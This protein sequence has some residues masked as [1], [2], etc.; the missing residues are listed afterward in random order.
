MNL[1]FLKAITVI[2]GVMIVVGVTVLGVLL[3]TRASDPASG[4][5]VVD[6][7]S[8]SLPEGTRFVAADGDTESLVLTLEK[9]STG[10]SMIAI[11]DVKSG[12]RIHL[13][14]LTPSE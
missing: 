8:L 4:K 10:T 12:K 13:F 14:E 6:A 5:E 2:M 9:I 3:F 7:R 11:H 1:A